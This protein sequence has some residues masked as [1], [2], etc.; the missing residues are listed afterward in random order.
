MASAG[1]AVEAHPQRAAPHLHERDRQGQRPRLRHHARRRGPAAGTPSTWRSRC[2]TSSTPASSSTASR[3]TTSSS[4][5]PSSASSSRTREFE[6]RSK[7]VL[8][9]IRKQATKD[10][11]VHPALSIPTGS[12]LA[13]AGREL[14]RQRGPQPV[15]PLGDHVR[16]LPRGR[17]DLREALDRGR[18]PR[19]VVR[20]PDARLG[21]HLR[22][23]GDAP[24]DGQPLATRSS[25]TSSR[26]CRATATPRSRRR[27]RRCSRSTT[28]TTTPPRCRSRSR[29]PGTGGPPVAAQRLAGHHQRPQP[30]RAAQAAGADVDRWPPGPSCRPG[31]PRPAGPARRD[32]ESRRRPPD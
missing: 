26:T 32:P 16:P 24:D 17:R 15:E 25:T 2:G 9:K 18:D 14:H 20:A 13:D 30:A 27:C 5:R 8:G 10:Y 11:V 28:S 22:L 19:R 3:P 7:A 1:R 23:Q 29:A 6:R 4:A 12:F 31:P 21:Q